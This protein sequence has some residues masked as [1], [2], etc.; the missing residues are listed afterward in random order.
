MLGTAVRER[1]LP[2]SCTSVFNDTG[3]PA[4]SV[5][6]GLAPEGLPC[7]EHIGVA[8]RG[9]RLSRAVTRPDS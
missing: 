3:H 9:H 6:A 8:G 2:I 1:T 5:P 4:I 7:A